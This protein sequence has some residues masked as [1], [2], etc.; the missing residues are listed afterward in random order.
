M[1]STFSFTLGDP[2]TVVDMSASLANGYSYCLVSATVSVV[3]EAKPDTSLNLFTFSN[4][5]Y[6][7]IV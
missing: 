5:S 6:G 1:H 2:N 3:K 7:N 4:L